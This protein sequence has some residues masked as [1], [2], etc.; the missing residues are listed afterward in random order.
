MSQTA[1]TWIGFE[2]KEVSGDITKDDKGITKIAC[3]CPT[4]MRSI[5]YHGGMLPLL[6]VCCVSFLDL[7]DI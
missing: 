3:V 2:L 7:E 5:G 4:S 1:S 6:R